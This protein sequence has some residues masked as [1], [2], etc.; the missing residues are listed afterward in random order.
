MNISVPHIAFLGDLTADVYVHQQ[1]V[2]LGGAALNCAIWAKR[3]GAEVS[4]LS[5]IGSDQIGKRF[6]KKIKA[7]GI[8]GTLV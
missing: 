5:A 6:D 4:I 7:E 2:K 8:D 1:K 3:A